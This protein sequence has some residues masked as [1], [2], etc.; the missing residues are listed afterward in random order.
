MAGGHRLIGL[1]TADGLP[2]G[3][4]ELPKSPLY[5]LKRTLSIFVG[6]LWKIWVPE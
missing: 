6:F 3:H 2:K 1:V 5:A 4:A